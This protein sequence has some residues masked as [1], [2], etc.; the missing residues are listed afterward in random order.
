MNE[1]EL[2]KACAQRMAEA[3][4]ASRMLGIEVEVPVPGQAR[5]TM[6]VREDMVNGFDL[7]H[8]GLIFTLADTA[9]AFAC[10]AYNQLTVAASANIEFLKPGKLGDTLVAAAS[11]EHRGRRSGV[12][13]V[14]VDNDRG[15]RVALFRGRSASADT[16]LL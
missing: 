13:S 11:E 15:E 16:T 1:L 4:E 10:N 7:C 2:A 6:R 8:G 14:I 3:D 9:F 12:Y 5:A